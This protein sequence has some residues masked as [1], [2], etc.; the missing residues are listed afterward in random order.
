MNMQFSLEGLSRPEPEM[1][2]IMLVT[3]YSCLLYAR[4]YAMW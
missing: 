3:I 2:K 4:I 1:D